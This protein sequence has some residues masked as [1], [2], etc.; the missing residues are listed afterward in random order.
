MI[1]SP[2]GHGNGDHRISDKKFQ[3]QICMKINS[4]RIGTLRGKPH[5]GFT[6][7]ELLVTITIIVVLAGLVFAITGKIRA[8]AQQANAMSSLR[9][10][11]IAN[12]AYSSE[13]NGAINVIRDKGEWGPFEGPGSKFA[14][15]SFV[16][17]MQPF[18]F[19][20]IGTKDEKTLGKE[21][22]SA[23]GALFNTSNLSSMAGTIFSGVPVYA[24]GSGISNPISVNSKL[25][26]VWGVNSP[27]LRISSFGNPASVLYL[28][29]GRYYFDLLQGSAYTPLPLPG[30]RR[31]GI[32]YL[33]NRKAIV[34]FLDGHIE[35]MSPPFPERLFQSTDS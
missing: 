19:A 4:S 31:R 7:V 15:N 3:N 26:P 14:S 12:V 11:G 17:R 30:E 32:Y 21:T 35:M 34:G 16:G 5:C 24:D 13:N 18:L 23:L 9:Q 8:S 33:P 20:G 1:I 28:T 29:Y 10:I 22:E 2:V 6:L 27:P 25:R